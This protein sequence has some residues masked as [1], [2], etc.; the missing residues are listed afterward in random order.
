MAYIPSLSGTSATISTPTFRKRMIFPRL[1][2]ISGKKK[3]FYWISTTISCWKNDNF[4]MFQARSTQNFSTS[5]R[6][7]FH[8]WNESDEWN[9]HQWWWN[10]QLFDPGANSDRKT[11]SWIAHARALEFSRINIQVNMTL[12]KLPTSIIRQIYPRHLVLILLRPTEL[13][14]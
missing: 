9:L 10:W 8:S 2:Q 12:S 6:R 1:I 5:R 14:S 3:N 4:A 13:H 7:L 11:D